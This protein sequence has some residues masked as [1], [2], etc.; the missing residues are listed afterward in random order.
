[1]VITVSCAVTN[2]KD[3]IVGVLG[4]DIQLE[5]LLQRAQALKQEVRSE[6]EE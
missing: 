2:A 5:Q 3:D 6:D 1:M 4:A